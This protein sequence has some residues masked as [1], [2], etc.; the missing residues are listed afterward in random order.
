[1]SKPLAD[2]SVS[3]K[4]SK[5]LSARFLT[6]LFELRKIKRILVHQTRDSASN[7]KLSNLR[8]L[9]PHP[10]ILAFYNLYIQVSAYH[11]KIK[12]YFCIKRNSDNF[13]KRS[14]KFQ[15]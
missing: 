15:D 3:K 4:N 1:M 5:K 8:Y 14:W 12:L 9:P 13:D 6:S 10:L 2:A 7:S 11:L